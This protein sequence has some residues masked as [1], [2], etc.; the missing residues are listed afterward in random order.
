M[1]AQRT[2]QHST[3]C[4][5]AGRS[6]AAALM[7]AS[8]LG[9]APHGVSQSEF[10]TRPQKNLSALRTDGGYDY[11]TF[12]VDG[13][14]ANLEGV[15]QSL[16]VLKTVTEFEGAEGKV[17]QTGGYA[18]GVVIFERFV[19]TVD[20]AVSD[21]ELESPSPTARSWFPP[22]RKSRRPIS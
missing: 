16:F 9:C 10:R 3:P 4:G 5:W 8:L 2:P 21:Y 18:T 20:H 14:K 13:R 6:L 12:F 11:N 15:L 7:S 17:Y 1:R 19:L 22:E